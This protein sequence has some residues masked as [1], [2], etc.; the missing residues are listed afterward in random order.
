MFGNLL[1]ASCAVLSSL[2]K[3]GEIDALLL[4]DSA[5]SNNFKIAL[6]CRFYPKEVKARLPKFITNSELSAE[7]QLNKESKEGLLERFKKIEKDKNVITIKK[8][9]YLDRLDYELKIINRMGFAGYFLIVADIVQ[10]AKI[11]GIPVKNMFANLKCF[12]LSRQM[13]FSNNLCWK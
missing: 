3:S 13:D 4:I 2:I 1:Y 8:Q 6:K 5:V 9:S 12:V 11:K 10:W 7:A